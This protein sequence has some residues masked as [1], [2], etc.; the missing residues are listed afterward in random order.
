MSKEITIKQCRDLREIITAFT[1]GCMMTEDEYN[2][3]MLILGRA[4][5]RL[6]KDGR[7][8]NE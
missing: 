6:E 5:D 2:D 1:S 3:I 8:H 7:I 4:A